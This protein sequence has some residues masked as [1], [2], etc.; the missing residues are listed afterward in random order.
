MAKKSKAILVKRIKF[1]RNVHF[2]QNFLWLEQSMDFSLLQEENETDKKK[3]T[4]LASCLKGRSHVY[5]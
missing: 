1:L 4:M 2:V 3:M 5:I